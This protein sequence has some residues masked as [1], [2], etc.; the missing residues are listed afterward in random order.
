MKRNLFNHKDLKFHKKVRLKILLILFIVTSSTLTYS[1]QIGSSLICAGGESFIAA[2]Q[3]LE[4]AIGEIA[5]GTF[6]SENSAL[7]EGF[8]QGSPRG[9]GIDEDHN[10]DLGV[11]IYPNPN[12][13]ATNESGFSSRGSGQ[14]GQTGNYSNLQ[15][16]F[17]MW[18][19]TENGDKAYHL[20]S[21]YNSHNTAFEAQP[22]TIGYSV[23]CLKN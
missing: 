1:Q 5:I 12:D 18:T 16:S 23:R 2:N 3:S 11:R 8:I 6:I 15:R 10:K 14:R 4:F 13:G 19:S 9:T 21:L 22:K 7:T 17:Q 20:S